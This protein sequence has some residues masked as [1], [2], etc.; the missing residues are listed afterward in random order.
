MPYHERSAFRLPPDGTKIWRFTDFTKF[1][2]ML[3]NTALYFSRLDKLEDTAG[4]G[5]NLLISPSPKKKERSCRS[6]LITLY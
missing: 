2:S 3:T 4:S 6:C 5:A 1:L